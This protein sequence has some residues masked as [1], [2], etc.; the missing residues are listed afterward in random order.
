MK[1]SAFTLIEL[2][3][4]ISIIALLA[5]I[6]L[7]VFNKAQEKG[8]ATAD[9]ANIR[10]IGIGIQTYLGDSD[11]QMFS[12][13]GAGGGGSAPAAWPVI[14]H[15]KYVP[16][17]KVFRSP[18]DRITRTRPDTEKEP[19]PVSYGINQNAFD[20]NV[21]KFVS[22][23]QFIL[24]APAMTAGK[25]IVFAGTSQTNVTLSM[26]TSSAN[27]Q[28]THSGRNQINVLFGDSHVSQML[29]NDFAATST[30]EGLK[31]WYPEG[32]ASA[33]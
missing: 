13:T 25:E 10:Q 16:N 31:H 9:A 17:W 5:A 12:L 26:P 30:E 2:L 4:V 22:P 1:K 6:A 24:S 18:F 20:T 14:L 29:W 21:S 7:P 27:K 15:N 3:V 19:V 8:R 33:P 28:G 11:D 32:K 23:S